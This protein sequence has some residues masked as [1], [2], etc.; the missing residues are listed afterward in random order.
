MVDKDDHVHIGDESVS[1]NHVKYWL[2]VQLAYDKI[3]DD[4]PTDLGEEETKMRRFASHSRSA[5]I[6]ADLLERHGKEEPLTYK[7]LA[8]LCGALNPEK[9]YSD[10]EIEEIVNLT[11]EKYRPHL[12]ALA[13]YGL[14]VRRYVNRRWEFE[15]TARFAR[16]FNE[17]IAPF[18][19]QE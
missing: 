10:A 7:E 4:P 6:C 3:F 17:N 1:R 9:E 2:G 12:E 5:L 11:R 16:K 18:L 19:R 13:R 15:I 8:K 14:V